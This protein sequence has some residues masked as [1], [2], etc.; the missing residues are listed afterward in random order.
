[1]RCIVEKLTEWCSIADDRK[2]FLIDLIDEAEDFHQADFIIHFKD[3]AN[4]KYQ[5][6]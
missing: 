5:C 1:M 4:E 3:A 6:A 2:G